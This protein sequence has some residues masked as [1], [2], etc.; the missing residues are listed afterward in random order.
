VYGQH[1]VHVRKT[2]RGFAQAC[3]LTHGCLLRCTPRVLPDKGTWQRG[4][5]K[6]VLAGLSKGSARSDRESQRTMGETGD[7]EKTR[8][9]C[10]RR[11]RGLT[12]YG[13]SGSQE[14]THAIRLHTLHRRST[15]P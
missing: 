14:H 7:V 15:P 2:T 5:D 3:S 10:L 13:R 6:L 12:A 9:R 4:A 11:R 8:S 1:R